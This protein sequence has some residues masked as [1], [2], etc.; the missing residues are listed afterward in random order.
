MALTNYWWL[1]IWLF[2]IGGFLKYKLPKQKMNVHGV[3]E[4]RWTILATIGLVLPY[5]IWAGTRGNFADTNAY[6][7]MFIEAPAQLSDLV[8]YTVKIDKDKGFS[9]F[10]VL[11]KSFISDSHVLFFSAVAFF[12]MFCVAYIF[13]KYS[14]DFWITFFL[15][16][17]SSSYLSWMFNGMRQFIAV[18]FCLL[19]TR[20][21]LDKN[22]LKSIILVIIASQ[23]HGTAWI[24]LIVF[25]IAQGQ[26]WNKK[27]LFFILLTILAVFYIGNFTNLLNDVLAG[28]QYGDMMSSDIWAQD[29]GTNI[30]RVMVNAV[31]AVL[32]F[33]GRKIIQKENNSLI[34]LCTN[35]SIIGTGIYLIS[36]VTSG[37]FIGRMPIYMM[38]YSYILLPWEIENFFTTKSKRIVYIMMMCGY[39]GYFYY[40][41]HFAFSLL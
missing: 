15:F 25:F 5:A 8:T 35:M 41:M 12:Q 40:Q 38:M 21:V 26:A 14:R 36:M 32:S 9:A 27:T 3:I 19:A 24:M 1:L 11:F 18:C 28:T 31:P 33:L 2:A 17:T 20:Y 16:I 39:L 7:K 10:I 22:Y 23:F 29:D 13:R 30:I 37:I 4:E 34:N 6:R